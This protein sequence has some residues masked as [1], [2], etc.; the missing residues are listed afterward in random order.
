MRR[1]R[2]PGLLLLM[3]L[4]SAVQIAV[5]DCPTLQD[6]TIRWIVPTR[7]GGG[8][9]AYSRLLEPFMERQ[10]GAQIVIENR[11]EAGGIVAAL[12]IRDAAPDGSTLGIINASGLLTANMLAENPAPHPAADFTVLGRVISNHFVMFTGRDSGIVDMEDLLSIAKARPVLVGVRDVGSASFA[13]LPI[14]ASLIGIEYAVITGYVG[15]SDRALAAIRGEVDVVMHNFESAR[16]FVDSGELI[17]LLQLSWPMP[18]AAGAHESLAGVPTLAGE[19][20]LARQRAGD[21]GRTQSQADQEARAL[22]SIIGAGRLLVAPPGME[23]SL[24]ECL[25]GAVTAVLRDPGLLSAAQR[26]G[27]S[28]APADAATALADLRIGEEALAQFA[29]LVRAAVE[30]ARQ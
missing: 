5:A 26:A 22:A 17:P 14:T 20:G 2:A 19:Q 6:S 7:P 11:A 16:R 30:R 13:A 9:D 12:T 29:T 1:L 25:R 3:L 8:Y 24:I 27:L 4:L 10:L 23:E 15:T 28:V 21:V 18:D